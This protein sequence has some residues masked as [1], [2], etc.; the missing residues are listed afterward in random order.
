MSLELAAQEERVLFGTSADCDYRPLFKVC[1][2][3]R[4][5]YRIVLHLQIRYGLK[6][7]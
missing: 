6:R 2:V 1:V 4:T 7:L 3:H 5:K